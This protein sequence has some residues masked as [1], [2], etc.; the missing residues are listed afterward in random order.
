LN[1]KEDESSD[2]SAKF[3]DELEDEEIAEAYN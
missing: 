2:D 1:K 3:Q